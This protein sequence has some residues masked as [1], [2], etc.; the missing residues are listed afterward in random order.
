MKGLNGVKSFA[1]YQR[2]F[3]TLCNVNERV[4]VTLTNLILFILL[5]NVF[6]LAVFLAFL[7]E[8]S[9]MTLLLVRTFK[10]EVES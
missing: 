1:S 7:Q 9:M 6:C 2:S 8:R 4:I 10:V 5:K 3:A